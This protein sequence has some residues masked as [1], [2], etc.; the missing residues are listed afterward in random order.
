MIRRKDNRLQQLAIACNR[1]NRKRNLILTFAI[2][3][4]VF[5]LF[6]AFSIAKGK[7]TI[8]SIKI[9]RESGSAAS[10][11]LENA[12]EEQ[13]K[14]LKALDYI[15][16]V[17]QEYTVGNWYQNNKLLAN[18][19][20]IDETAYERIIK[21]A[22]DDIKG[23]YP[24]DTNEIMLSK[25]LLQK[26]GISNPQLGM[27]I[28]IPILF[29][30]WSVNDGN[31]L[32][33]EFFLVGYYNDY[34][35]EV[36][37]VP[38]A[39][40]SEKYL[41][42]KQISRYPV[43]LSIIFKS[44]FLSNMQ[45][46]QK[47]YQDV[48]LENAQQQFSSNGSAEFRSVN[49][50]IGGYGVAFLCIIIVLLSVYLLIYNVFS[51]S[52]AKDIHYYG[53]LLVIGTTQKQLRKLIASQ[54][55]AILI[56]GILLGS[57]LSLLAG[58]VGFPILFKGLFLQGNG[59][60]SMDTV[61]YPE[62]LIGAVVVVIILMLSASN[63][64]IGKLKKMSPVEAYKY[65]AK[66]VSRRKHTES[67]K[68]TSIC[69]MAWY[70]FSC[71]K[72]KSCIALI[73]LFIGCEMALLS[74]FISNGTDVINKFL[75]QPDFEIGTKKDA[76]N[77]YLFPYSTVDELQVDREKSLLDEMLIEKIISIDEIDEDSI[78]QIY[79]C[80]AAFDYN[81]EFIQPKV[82]A[83]YGTGTSNDV[84]TIQV[85]DDQYIQILQEYAARNQ[86]NVDIASLKNGTG[87][88][89]LH[90]HELSEMLEDDADQAVGESAHVYPMETMD[91]SEAEGKEFVCSG[92]IDT[93][94]KDFPQLS[95]SWNGEGINYF[96]VSEQG[97]ER[98]NY[99]K[100]V[101]SFTVDA[102]NGQE[103][104]VKEKL[105]KLIQ[106]EN[107]KQ[108][109][110]DIYYLSC[111]SDKIREVKNYRNSSRAV[112]LAL[113]LSLSL[114]GIANY[115]N[116]ITTNIAVRKKDFIIMEKI[117]MTHKQLKKMLIMESLYYWGIL[118]IVLLSVGTLM[119]VGIGH[120]IK[121]TL[122]YFSFS[123]PIKEFLII[124][125][126]LLAFCV[127]VPQVFLKEVCREGKTTN[128]DRAV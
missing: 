43:R 40:L 75:Q 104:V 109:D 60:I 71:S 26:L 48:E 126:I 5:V 90:K 108:E 99:P 22:Y 88:L 1:E 24:S 25:R 91:M 33:E 101:F 53:L 69:R 122:P 46:E 68:G 51:I 65:Q 41:E 96:L 19:K 57:V 105:T 100:Q 72:R 30:S 79:G 127:F 32:T 11:Y 113:C 128:R 117:G 6:S 62:I 87:I 121:N 110:F 106:E 125:I 111:T 123:Y 31:E 58:S 15:T 95:M 85:I 47:L 36:Q 10:A 45:M 77:A 93:T 28:S 89:V 2:T 9:I 17:G 124:V 59:E 16:Y 82:N 102:C 84:M 83:A 44:G 73:S 61:L 94:R 107:S 52:L 39:Y 34:I 38:V 49:Q 103:A 18:C 115:I 4:T 76:V 3:L 114:L 97:Y 20:V 78:G 67:P 23:H 35:D 56:K 13:Y 54:N 98:L 55:R 66:T 29:D 12:E 42:S 8:D 7:L 74:S 81:E 70:N 118:I 50:L 14:K 119:A 80:Y 92:Y 37:Y 63:H 64:V 116:V 120:I 112:M 21:P 86:L 27:K